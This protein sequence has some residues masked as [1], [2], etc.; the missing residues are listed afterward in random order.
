[1]FVGSDTDDSVEDD[2]RTKSAFKQG[3]YDAAL[4]PE[5]EFPMKPKTSTEILL[6]AYLKV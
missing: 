4:K 5:V 3:S 2:V 1:M 6:K